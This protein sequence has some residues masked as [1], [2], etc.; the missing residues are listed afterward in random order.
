MSSSQASENAA[1]LASASASARNPLLS[2]SSL[3]SL[4]SCSAEENS[5]SLAAAASRT[6][7]TD[8]GSGSPSLLAPPRLL[9]RRAEACSVHTVAVAIL[10][11]RQNK[12]QKFFITNKNRLCSK[13]CGIHKK[14][15]KSQGKNLLR[16]P[17]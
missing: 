9:D 7:R 10:G 12:L 13:T 14:E 1:A 17:I 8:S 2:A 15:K 6:R 5:S 11:D 3:R 16:D 4:C